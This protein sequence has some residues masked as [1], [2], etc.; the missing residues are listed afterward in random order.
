[1]RPMD[2]HISLKDR[3]QEECQA[4]AA[5]GTVMG[6]A[7]VVLVGPDADLDPLNKRVVVQDVIF[8]QSFLLAP[9]SWPTGHC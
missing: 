3:I 1:M 2:D 5:F 9:V 8:P 6:L 4:A 7:T